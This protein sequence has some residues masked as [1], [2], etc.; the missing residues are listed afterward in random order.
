MPEN[1]ARQARPIKKIFELRLDP[2]GEVGDKSVDP[3]PALDVRLHEEQ[4]PGIPVAPQLISTAPVSGA[5]GTI[6]HG[7]GGSPNLQAETTIAANDDGS[8]LIAGYNDS[9]GFSVD[10]ALGRSISGVARS[11]DGGMTWTTAPLFQS[12][13]VLPSVPNADVFGDPDVKYDRVNRRWIYSS[14]YQVNG[15]SGLCIHTSNDGASWNGPLVVGPAL[16]AA[17]I[18]AD[19]EFIDV[20][21]VTG[22]IIATWARILIGSSSV[23][24]QIRFTFSDDGGQTW[25]AT[26]TLSTSGTIVTGP[27]PRFYAPL[28]STNATSKIFVAWRHITDNGTTAALVNTSFVRSLDGG[29]TWST[30]FELGSSYVGDDDILGVDRTNT[31][32]SMAVDPSDGRVYVVYQFNNSL[33]EGDIAIQWS[34]N[35]WTSFTSRMLINSNPG[36]DRAQFFPSVAVDPSNGYVHVV[37][38]DQDADTSG[39]LMEWMHSVSRDRGMTWTRPTPLLAARAFHAGYG[40]DTSQPNAGDY[41]QNI[42]RNGVHHAVAMATSIAPRFDEGGAPS[43][44]AMLTPDVY[45]DRLPDP[46]P[47]TPDPAALR[48]GNVTF[49]ETNCPIGGNGNLDP[50]ETANL[51]IPLR[52][53]VN[54]SGPFT[55]T[56]AYTGVSATLSTATAGVTITSATSAYPD[57]APLATQTNSV[58]FQIA[59]DS[60]FAAGTPIDFVL[61]ANAAQGSIARPYRLGTGTPGATT[62]LLSED[63]ESTPVGSLPDGWTSVHVNGAGPT[64]VV[65]WTTSTAL[66]SS[67]AAYHTEVGG[68]VTGNSMNWERLFSPLMLVPSTTAPSYVTVDFDIVYNLE[69]EPSLRILAYDG[70]TLQIFDASY[71]PVR[72]VMAEAFAEIIRTGNIKHFPKHLISRNGGYSNYLDAVAA[73]SGN[74]QGSQHVFMKFPGTGMVGHQIQLRFEYTEDENT[75]CRVP[76]CGVAID[77]IVVRH[78]LS[79]NGSCLLTMPGLAIGKSAVASTR[80]GAQVLYNVTV[81]NSGPVDASGVVVSDSPGTGFSFISNSGDCSTPYP[82]NLGTIPSGQ[83]RNIRSLLRLSSDYTSPTVQNVATLTSISSLDPNRSVTSATATTA[84]SDVNADVAVT[85]SAPSTA[86]VGVT[87][88]YTVSVQNNGPTDASDVVVRNTTPP[89]LAF[90]SNTGACTTPFPCSL[91]TVHPTASDTR[92]ITSQYS[93][94][95]G[96]MSPN[97][98]QDTVT[99]ESSSPDPN[100]NNNSASASTTILGLPLSAGNKG[101]CGCSA[102]GGFPSAA[103][104]LFVLAFLRRRRV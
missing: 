74:S 54:G 89:G 25:A 85:L 9:R 23:D 27:I 93:I 78:V 35:P 58:P 3:I 29:A 101:G 98:I 69:D 13:P 50:G 77:N 75:A 32:P 21:P 26:H 72:S 90:L 84:V 31:N 47:G 38:Y 64:T 73:W 43:P 10:R 86:A 49:V 11:T 56:G 8:I 61:T 20:N 24:Y 39:D 22:R 97:P 52:N 57:I 15:Q 87:L 1:T 55:L 76:P 82:C 79:G 83:S 45:Y 95:A 67:N 7:T 5:G 19:K 6:I 103:L 94:P 68:P 62:T 102:L 66:T 65:P 42:A 34:N 100:S 99:V 37:Y 44:R 18:L 12:L 88:T 28:G 16:E 53:Y 96:Y 91:G 60:N 17:G 4:I 30:P 14:L 81:T 40:N 48:L 71:N 59:V 63:F 46:P 104:G 33:G 41:N 2:A 92:T 51:Q 80:R 36:F 70:V